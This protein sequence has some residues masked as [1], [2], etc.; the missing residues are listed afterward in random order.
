MAP[1]AELDP[2]VLVG[3]PSLLA[4][5]ADEAACGRLRMAPHKVI[6]VA[7]TLEPPDE[8]RIA[9]A[10]GAPVHQVYQ[11][12][13]GFLAATCRRGTLHVNEDIVAIEPEWLDGTAADL[14][15]DRGTAT[16]VMPAGAHP[17]RASG[18]HFVPIAQRGA[19]TLG[20][21]GTHGVPWPDAE[22]AAPGTRTGPE[23]A[24]GGP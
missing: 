7:E 12:T 18:T 22:D 1:L 4:A 9:A 3:P 24:R 15:G 2:T 6:S 17:H 10:F 5:L 21:A 14:A 13:E 23:S 19:R 20:C 8:A 11:A 16:A